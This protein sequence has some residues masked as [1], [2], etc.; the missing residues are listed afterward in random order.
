MAMLKMLSIVA[1]AAL[2]VF[3]V[4][5]SFPKRRVVLVFEVERMFPPPRQVVAPPPASVNPY[6]SKWS[7]VLSSC[8]RYC[9]RMMISPPK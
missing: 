1:L 8:F 3:G 2:C 4:F 9:C 7:V 6:W 5:S